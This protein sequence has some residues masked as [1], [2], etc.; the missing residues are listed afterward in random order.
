MSTFSLSALSPGGR[1][2]F[3]ALPG[4]GTSLTSPPGGA[5]TGSG[6]GGPAHAHEFQCPECPKI[7]S[8][9]ATL[10]AHRKAHD[11]KV[12]DHVTCSRDFQPMVVA[13]NSDL[14]KRQSQKSE[15]RDT[16]TET[17]SQKER[18]RKR[19]THPPGPLHA[20]GERE[21][22]RERERAI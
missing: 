7:C 8:S 3:P 16:R 4:A 17:G 9:I 19:E 14:L 21:T 13:K 2:V 12:R 1:V 18:N 15:Q 5:G 10:T 20:A 22:D 11:R 6:S